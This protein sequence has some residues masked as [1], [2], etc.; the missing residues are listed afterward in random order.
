MVDKQTDVVSEKF[1]LILCFCRSDWESVTLL[2]A[3]PPHSHGS[4]PRKEESVQDDNM[5]LYCD[6][7]VYLHQTT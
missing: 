3:F 4:P 2:D 5:A 7:Y 1:S 6:Q